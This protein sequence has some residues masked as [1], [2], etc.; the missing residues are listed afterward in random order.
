MRLAYF[1]YLVLSLALVGCAKNEW[2]SGEKAM[3]I[4]SCVANGGNIKACQCTLEKLQ[5]K[6]TFAEFEKTSLDQA[7]PVILK[8]TQEC[9]N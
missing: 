8:L 5:K 7:Y 1:I 4:Q 6:Y 3:F 9:Q 2:P